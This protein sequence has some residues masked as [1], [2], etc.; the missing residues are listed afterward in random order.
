[1]TRLTPLRRTL[2][3][4]MRLS[5]RLA[6]LLVFVPLVASAQFKDLDAAVKNLKSGFGTGNPQAIVAGM[7]TG[8]KVMLQFPGLID[9]R[10]FFGRDQASYLLDG[11][12]TKVRPTAFE[13]QKATKKSAEAQYHITA[14]W[15]IQNAGKPE[16]R[17]LYITLRQTA[18][19]QWS[20]VSIQSAGK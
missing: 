13:E 7:A 3:Y 8:D 12:F 9:Q 4:I 14:T 10:G 5:T 16:T 19:N 20:V 1:M 2:E 11:L 17:E 18:D 6:L 15:T